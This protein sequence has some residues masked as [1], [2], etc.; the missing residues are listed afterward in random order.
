M[1]ELLAERV[2][3]VEAQVEAA[4]KAMNFARQ[5]LEKRLDILSESKEQSGSFITRGELLTT[6][7]AIIAIATFMSKFIK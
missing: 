7:I 6:A 5:T 2:A 1:S 4:E 3:K